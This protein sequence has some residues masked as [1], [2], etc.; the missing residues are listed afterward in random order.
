MHSRATALSRLRHPSQP[1]PEIKFSFCCRVSSKAM[2]SI[3]ETAEALLQFLEE[4]KQKDRD[5]L[6]SLAAARALGRCGNSFAF[7]DFKL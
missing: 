7:L 2:L 6:L 3:A 5:D 1:A 4:M